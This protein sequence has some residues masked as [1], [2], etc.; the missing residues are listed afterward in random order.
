MCVFNKRFDLE[1]NYLNPKN[2]GIWLIVAAMK[3]A[4]RLEYR[5]LMRSV[6]FVGFFV[7]PF[8][9]KRNRIA[10]VNLRIA[11]PD[12]K[13]KEIRSIVR[14]SYNSMMLSGAESIIAWFYSDEQF[15]KI[16]IEFDPG[17]YFEEAHA[18]PR[19]TVLLLGYHFHSLEI[20]G[21]YTGK[22]YKPLTVM[23]QKNGNSLLEDL[24]KEYREQNIDKC[25]DSNNFIS[26]IKSLKRHVTMWYAPDQD[27]GLDSSGYKNS[28]FAPFFGTDCLTLTVTPWLAQKTGAIVLPI[29][30]VRKPNLS[31]YKIVVG[32]PLDFTGDTYVDATITNKFLE[33]VIREYPEQYLWQHRR[34]RTRPDGESQIY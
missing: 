3:T 13:E 2:F 31:G 19:K 5:T 1:R 27:F 22:N 18:N 28:V 30:Y 25:F 9:K 7:K 20:A 23:Y 15:N 11:F 24:I 16:D 14:E 32:N 4:S 29:Y 33:N 10:R 6:L 12:L 8:L 34:Y 26:V 17:K 21:R